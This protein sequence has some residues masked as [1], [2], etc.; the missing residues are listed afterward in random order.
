M[1]S[2]TEILQPVPV[3]A[4]RVTSGGDLKERIEN[5]LDAKWKAE[6]STWSHRGMWFLALCILPL[7]LMSADASDAETATSDENASTAPVQ[8]V[9]PLH[10]RN[11]PA[12]VQ[13]RQ[14]VAPEL[15]DAAVL[16][17]QVNFLNEQF[18]RTDA[19]YRTGAQGGT[20]DRWAM[21]GYELAKTRGE[22]ALAEG[23]RVEATARFSEALGFAEQSLKA[24]SAAYHADRVTLDTLLSASKNLTDVRRRLIQLRRAP[25][26]AMTGPTVEDVEADLRSAAS[27]AAVGRE[28]PVAGDASQDDFATERQI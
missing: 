12:I 14:I 15:D 9:A 28:W 11:P 20:V 2:A 19:L 17:D 16:R 25:A 6:M 10:R 27:A 8:V 7:S 4:S 22:L 24:T 5:V 3:L 21:T 18:K 26:A 1:Q 23:N 13:E